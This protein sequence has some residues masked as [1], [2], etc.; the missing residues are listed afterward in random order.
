MQPI[1]TYVFMVNNLKRYIQEEEK[2]E[3]KTKLIFHIY[4]NISNKTLFK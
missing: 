4:D 3:W 1:A 2:K